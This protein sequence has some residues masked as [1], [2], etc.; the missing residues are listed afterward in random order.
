MRMIAIV[1]SVHSPWQF[2]P[3][4]SHVAATSGAR[5]S[6]RGFTAAALRK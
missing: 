4:C 5:Y 2:A 1:T 6:R 3:M